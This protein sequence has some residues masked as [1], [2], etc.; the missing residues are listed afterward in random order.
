MANHFIVY[1]VRNGVE[2]FF[3][4]I[5]DPSFFVGI[6]KI[7]DDKLFLQYADPLHDETHTFPGLFEFVCA[8]EGL[9]IAD[10]ATF[11]KA[12]RAQ[13]NGSAAKGLY[14]RMVLLDEK[15]DPLAGPL[16][17]LGQ[18][19]FEG[20]P[21]LNPHGI[22]QHSKPQERIGYD[23]NVSSRGN[24]EEYVVRRLKRDAPEL[25]TALA[26]GDFPSA[27]AA[28]IAAGFV[29]PS[30]PSIQLKDPAPTAQKLL[31]KKGQAWCLQL[32]EELSELC[33]EM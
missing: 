1:S 33:Y 23:S 21:P 6:N 30:P 4:G 11:M 13:D 17:A 7:L 2:S 9:D 16:S 29:K 25:A 27:R 14:W 10:W 20:M 15:L 26:R 3:R 28:G 12:L 18:A 8:K 31:A 19:P 24:S 22:N 32:L 5:T